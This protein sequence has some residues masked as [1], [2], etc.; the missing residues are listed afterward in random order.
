MKIIEF[1]RDIFTPGKTIYVQ[2]KLE[3]QKYKL[4]IEG[5]SVQMAINLLAG[6][7][8][9]C[10]FKTYIKGAEKKADEYY[11][12][13]LDPNVNQNSSQFVQELIS[14]LLFR[15]EVL[16]VEV[17]GQLLIADSFSVTEYTLF[18]NTFTGV[19]V[20]DFTFDKSFSMTDVL[21]FRLNDQ[22]IRAM[23]S[24]LM[25]G[26]SELLD[27]AVGKYKRAGG[28]KG[29]AKVN[30]TATGD[31]KGKE[32]FDDL[33]NKQFK[34]Y[35]NSENAV[36]QLP[37]GVEYT[38][39][40]GEGSKKS[41]S[42]VNDITN[43]TKEAISRVA[44]AFRIPPALLQ[45]D[46]ADVDKLVDELLTFC[47]DPLTDLIQTEINRKRYG[48]VAYLAGTYLRIDTTCIKHIDVFDV[49]Q[50][51]DKL[52]SDSIYDPDEIRQK[53]GDAP[54]NAWWSTQYTR[55]KNIEALPDNE[56]AG[57]LNTGG[58]G[59]G[60]NETDQNNLGG[61]TGSGSA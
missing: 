54:L 34:T 29:V 19:T 5:F 20:G 1:L 45:G 28:R 21:Y 13:N 3:S 27:M 36:V 41:T 10:E 60:K 25:A 11:L 58:E 9:K 51:V 23:L 32:Q 8:A 56:P 42:E 39:I 47:I 44:Q 55:T 35:F 15:N 40:T 57:L 61:E 37:N 46:I 16:V 4:A 18:P 12:W 6:L 31:Q 43:I 17:N 48:K 53:L 38:E 30:K 7:L 14:K 33:F 26:Y 24:G 50:A 59:N 49:A 52:I 22:N 2:Q